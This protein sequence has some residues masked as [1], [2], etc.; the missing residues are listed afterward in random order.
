MQVDSEKQQAAVPILSWSGLNY[1]VKSGK[2]VRRILHNVCG[3][4]YPGELVAIMGSSGA[5][6]TT[7]LN[8]LSG[9][10][11]GG[12]LYGDIKFNGSKRVPHTFK[13]ML[14]YVEQD[15]LMFPQLTVEETLTASARLRLSDKKYTE[16]QKRERVEMV[17]RQLRLSHVKN[18]AI[19]G[20]GGRGVSGGE[21]KRVSIGVE[22]VTD[23]A[24]LVLDEPSSGL[25]SSSAEMVVT[26]T[27]DMTKE[28]N[29]CTLMTIHQPSAEM[30]AQFDKLILLSQGKL[31]YMGP[32]KQAVPYFESIGF[33]STHSNPANFF[34]DLTTIDF[35]SDKAMQES[36]QHVQNLADAFVKFRESGGQLPA[37]AS[38]GKHSPSINTAHGSGAVSSY[39]SSEVNNDI[40]QE[41]ASLVLTEPPP[42]NSWFNEF[43]VLLKRDWTL[44]VRN[45]YMLYGLAAMSLSTIIFLGFVF[46]QLDTD[47][48]SVQNRIGALFMFALLCSYPLIFPVVTMILMGRGVLLRERSAGT[49]RMT[50]YFFAKALSFFPLGV[51]PYTITFIGVYFIAHFQY[52][53][54]KFFIALANTYVL[55]FTVIGFAF[56]IAMI[57]HQMEVAFIIAPVT[58]STLVLFAGNLS[59]SRSITPVLRWIRYV[60]MFYYTYSAFIQNEL[61]GL[62][63]TCSDSSPSCYHTGEEVVGAYGLDAQSIWLCIVLNIVLGIGNYIIAYA[64]TRWRVKPRYLWI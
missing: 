23:P 43:R 54:A 60:C 45:R 24:I 8:V 48:E 63:F 59:N 4:I 47:Q 36:E 5:G 18:T 10:V 64:L 50:S 38:S 61:N 9:R 40:T 56:G 31:I 22:L 58:L 25:D 13:R 51:I 26:L 57:T 1:D 3:S 15:D 17:M 27:K 55:L 37:P 28:R 62:E 14:S 11:Q 46:F 39:S 52:D 2:D 29:L 6:K 12:R 30:V 33:P 34:I 32:T 35:S 44:V 42:M 21:R 7:L 49:Y 16:E 20:Y 19:G 41:L 53:A